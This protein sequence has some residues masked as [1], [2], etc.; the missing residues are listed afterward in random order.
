MIVGE[1]IR[2]R[3]ESLG[4]TQD[5]LAERMGYKSRSTIAKIEKGVNDVTQ[6]TLLKFAE[7]LKTTPSYLMG[8]EDKGNQNNRIVPLVA[9]MREDDKFLNLVDEFQ[10]NSDKLKPLVTMM[11][12]DDEFLDMVVELARLDDNQRA[13]IRSLLSAFKQ[14]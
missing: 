1:K 11:C 4:M 12:E 8:W 9:I 14:K 10:K 3:R 13:S 7:V 5:D 2:T 6:T